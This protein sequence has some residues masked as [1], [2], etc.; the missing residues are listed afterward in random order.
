MDQLQAQ[1]DFCD[2]LIQADVYNNT[3][4]VYKK[5]LLTRYHDKFE[6]EKL[7]NI[8]KHDLTLLL[9]KPDNASL[10]VYLCSMLPLYFYKNSSCIET[11]TCMKEKCPGAWNT[12]AYN[13][14]KNSCI[15]SS[16]ILNLILQIERDQD[17]RLEIIKMLNIV[18][19][20]RCQVNAN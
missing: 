2:F 9:E 12:C 1:L 19:P 20:I 8:G 3:A 4:W 13:T 11:D 17:R 14:L 6:A 10:G 7:A 16:P 5:Y 15:L 18:D